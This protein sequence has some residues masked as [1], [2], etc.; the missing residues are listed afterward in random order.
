LFSYF[1]KIPSYSRIGNPAV[2]TCLIALLMEHP[3]SPNEFG[4][5]SMRLDILLGDKANGRVPLYPSV[6]L[7][8]GTIL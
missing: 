8:L 7:C 3:S 2:D 1:I 4:G 6:A 5:R